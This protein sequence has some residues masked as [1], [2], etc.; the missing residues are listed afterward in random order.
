MKSEEKKLNLGAGWKWK[1]LEGWKVLDHSVSNFLFLRK[2]AWE[3]PYQDDRFS[4]VFCSNMIEHV[5]H[6]KIEQVICEINRVMKR[7]GILRLIT[8][9]L[10]KIATAYVNKDYNTLKIY[11]D[12]D[13]TVKKAALGLGQVFL[14]FIVSPGVDNY[15]LSSDFSEIIAGY[16]HVYSF[17]YEMLSELLRYYGFNDI[18]ECAIDESEIKEHKKLRSAPYDKEACYV[19]VI[20][21]KK[22]KYVPYNYEKALLRRLG[23]YNVKTLIP[24]KYSPFWFI[25][26]AVG[27]LYILYMHMYKLLVKLRIK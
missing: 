25:F 9:D 24:R 19:L 13:D 22:K 21:C 10:R 16:A 17:D 5:S 8:P 11:T 23:P 14:N 27:H 2:Q 1:R 6:Y 7:D 3:L 12:E 20:E 15:L 4:E 18:R 26:K